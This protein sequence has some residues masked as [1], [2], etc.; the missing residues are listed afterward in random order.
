MSHG[1]GILMRTKINVS[2]GIKTA[3]GTMEFGTACWI[4]GHVL[5]VQTQGFMRPGSTCEIKLDL[6]PAGGWIYAPAQVMHTSAQIKHELC[7]AVLRLLELDERDQERLETFAE[8]HRQ[9]SII[10][11]APAPGI[12]FTGQVEPPASNAAVPIREPQ[13][14]LSS[15]ERRLTVRWSDNRSFRQDWAIHLAHGR[16]LAQ[17]PR[18]FRRAF[19]LRIVLPNGF[20]ATFPAEVGETTHEG[21]NARFLIP[22]A[23]RRRLEIYAQA[24]PKRSVINAK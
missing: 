5:M 18:P 10:R 11:R 16:L 1:E 23:A 14:Q 2:V 15:D 17:C 8:I 19:M 24:A 20:V 22:F 13:F 9:R 6:E 12:S 3:Q 21:W 4:E 7:D